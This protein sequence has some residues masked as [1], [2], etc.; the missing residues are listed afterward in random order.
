VTVNTTR[1]LELV[2]AELDG[3]LSVPERAELARLLLQDP[4]ARRLQ[5]EL[6][7]TDRLLRDIAQAEPPPELRSAILAG[8]A[9]QSGRPRIRRLTG[10]GWPGYRMAAVILGGLLIVGLSYLV[11]DGN[12][13]GRNLQGSLNRIAPHELSLQSE[14]AS[15]GASLHRRGETLRLELDLLTNVPCEVIAR[16]DPA[17]TT[18]V[19]R[20]G[21]AKLAAAK[22]QISVQPGIGRQHLVL[23]FAGAGLIQLQLRSGGRLLGEGT[24]RVND[25][26]DRE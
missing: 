11:S 6:R 23:E 15:L 24:L 10:H 21:E 13:P 7:T 26:Q 4:G 9:Q 19:A 8:A 2:Q 20:T 25:A 1:L 12:A 17:A 5:G 3:E 16:I 18:F 22:D 14:G